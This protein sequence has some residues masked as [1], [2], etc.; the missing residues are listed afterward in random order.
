MLYRPV[1]DLK[2]GMPALTLIPAP[3]NAIMFFLLAS[4]L[5]TESSLSSN[6]S[7][8]M[9]SADKS[10]ILGKGYPTL[11]KIEADVKVKQWNGTEEAGRDG[12]GDYRKVVRAVKAGVTLSLRVGWRNT[13]DDTT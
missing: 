2:S 3:T 9:G 10:S 5:A 8:W 4:K 1:A 6:V 11:K 7:P 13:G 12:G